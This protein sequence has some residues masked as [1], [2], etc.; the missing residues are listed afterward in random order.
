[1][2]ADDFAHS[3]REDIT[4]PGLLYAGMEHGIWVSFKDGETWQPLQLKLPDTQIADIQV[5]EKDVVIGTHGRS[6]YVLDDIAP[7]REFTPDLAK[8]PV[9]LFKPYY[10]VRRVQPAV[11]QY[12]LAKQADSVKVEILDAAGTVIQSFTGNKP[13]NPKNGRG[14]RR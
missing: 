10:A 8:K 6:I 4:R 2:R 5:T 3:I 7:V 1:M 12:Y 13:T 9:H 14:R 11:F